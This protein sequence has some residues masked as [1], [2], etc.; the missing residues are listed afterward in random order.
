[1]LRNRGRRS[2]D[3]PAQARGFALKKEIQR[4]RAMGTL[5]DVGPHTLELW[6]V[7]ISNK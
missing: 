2:V 1:M 3:V 5:Q 6:R 7:C 4:E